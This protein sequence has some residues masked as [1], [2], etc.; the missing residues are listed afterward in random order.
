MDTRDWKL[1]TIGDKIDFWWKLHILEH[2]LTRH[3]VEV[4][5]TGTCFD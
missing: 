4:A 3:L 5:H 2:V 1:F